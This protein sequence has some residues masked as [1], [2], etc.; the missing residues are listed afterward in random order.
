MK[1]LL[2]TNALIWAMLMPE[3]LPPSIYSKL[4]DESNYIYFSAV[5]IWEIAIKSS[6]N[7]FSLRGGQPS[8]IHQEATDIGFKEIQLSCKAAS[9]Y[10]NLPY[11][12]NHLDPF[13]RM[14]IWQAISER[15]PIISSDKKFAL[16]ESIGL[17]RIW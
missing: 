2:D 3:K 4:E 10:V 12:E 11:V 8:H 15:L 6:K 17:N 14:L 1:Y 9:G 16:Y 7:K 5:S 13:D